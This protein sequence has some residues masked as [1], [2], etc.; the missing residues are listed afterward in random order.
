[1][2][3]SD[4][5][6]RYQYVAHQV[7]KK[8]PVG[9]CDTTRS[10]VEDHTKN[11]A[12]PYAHKSSATALTLLEVPD[13]TED[14]RTE[15]ESYPKVCVY[16]A[17]TG[18]IMFLGCLKL[19]TLFIFAFFG[20]VVTPAYYDKEGFS[21]TVARTAFCA[22]AP[23]VFVAYITSPFVTFIHM[24][25]PPFALRSEEMLSRYVI[26]PQAELE[27][28]TMSIISKL[29]V[30]TVK[31]SELEPVNRRFGIVTMAR[32]TTAENAAR[33]WY[34]F[35]A[36][37]NFSVQRLNGQLGPNKQP[38]AWHNIWEAYTARR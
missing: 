7:I 37:G 21:P 22:I 31:L 8:Y 9:A 10:R 4:A 23:L 29:R 12:S 15:V 19:S 3:P 1:M 35:P 25:L 30:S 16:H 34:M 6:S 24:R 33:K 38:W 32:D 2:G 20:F 27:I 18:R 17:G 11:C 5:L 13:N 36:V 28:T 14:S 26:S